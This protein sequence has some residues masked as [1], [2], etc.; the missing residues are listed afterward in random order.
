MWILA[1]IGLAGA[2][3]VL[4]LYCCVVVGS[5]CDRQATKRRERGR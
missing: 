5:R 3:F 2:A 1:L 4:A